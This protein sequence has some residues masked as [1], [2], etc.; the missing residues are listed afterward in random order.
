MSSRKRHEEGELAR[1]LGGVEERRHRGLLLYLLPKEPLHE[2]I[3]GPRVAAG[4]V[5][6]A[7]CDLFR[8]R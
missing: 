4:D 8:G 6:V 3:A 1:T 2:R 7:C 5:A